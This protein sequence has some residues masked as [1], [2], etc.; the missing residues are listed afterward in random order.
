MVVDGAFVIG[1]VVNPQSKAA[2]RPATSG[3]PNV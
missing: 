2:D 1:R 3:A